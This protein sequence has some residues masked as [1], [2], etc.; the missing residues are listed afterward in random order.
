MARRQG[1]EERSV[2]LIQHSKLGK[3]NQWSETTTV[4][5]HDDLL[6]LI[7]THDGYSDCGNWRFRGLRLVWLLVCQ[8]FNDYADRKL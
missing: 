3:N 5:L 2:V 1:K 6:E 8:L 7:N 4:I